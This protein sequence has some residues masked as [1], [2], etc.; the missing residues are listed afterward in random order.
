MR[1]NLLL[2]FLL[3]TGFFYG[4]A[5]AGQGLNDW[6]IQVEGGAAVIKNDVA[7][8]REEAIRNSLEKAIMQAAAQILLNQFENE[9]FQAVK[10]IMIDKADRYVKNYR[11]I[12]ENR[13]HDDYAVKVNV[14][15]ALAAVREDLL[16]MGVLRGQGDKESVTVALLLKGVK[17]YSDFDRLKTF[18]QN[19]PKIVESIYP[20]RLEWEQVHFDLVVG[21]VRD[22]AAELEKTGRYLVAAPRKNQDGVEITLQL[23][24]EE[25]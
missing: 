22:L 8:A 10:S 21:S 13:Q 1:K 11:I 3:L 12:S 18:L 25:R 24:E 14:V 16:Q 4:S 2:M 23:K 9:K 6:T 20:C 19:R 5:Y 7:L 17:K 15:V